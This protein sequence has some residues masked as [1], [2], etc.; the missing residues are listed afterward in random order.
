MWRRRRRWSLPRVR[1]RR[2]SGRR[3]RSGARVCGRRR[4]SAR[5]GLRPRARSSARARRACAAGRVGPCPLRRRGGRA[6]QNLAGSRDVRDPACDVHRRSEPVVAASY[7][8]AGVHGHP[9][10]E[11]AIARAELAD[12]PRAEVQRLCWFSDPQK[13]RIA[14][15]LDLFGAV[16][17]SSA[18]TASQN[19][20]ATSAA[21]SSPW[22]SVSAV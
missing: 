21:C 11:R 16:A 19:S 5:T 8:R 12:D 15:R 18:R 9:D 3:G 20:A 7:C 22:A 13:Q 4:G 1:G 14:D 6:D 2:P 17:S 10:T